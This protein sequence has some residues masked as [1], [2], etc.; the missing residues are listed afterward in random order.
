MYPIMAVR[1]VLISWL[2][3]RDEIGLSLPRRLGSLSCREHRSVGAFALDRGGH[4]LGVRRQK[5]QVV[6]RPLVALSHVLDDD[7]PERVGERRD[8]NGDQGARATVAKQRLFVVGARGQL[9]DVVDDDL[10]TSS[11]ARFP[12]FG[13]SRVDTKGWGPSSRPSSTENGWSA[14]LTRRAQ[15]TWRCRR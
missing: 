11:L 9:G 4:E 3:V 8:W 1:G 12:P 2:R 15:Q 14:D 5:R 6:G 7:V 10:L 13:S